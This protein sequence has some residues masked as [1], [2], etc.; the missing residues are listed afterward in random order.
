M[1]ISTVFK[2]KW[3]EHSSCLEPGQR[4]ESICSKRRRHVY[5]GT[6]N[7]RNQFYCPDNGVCL[8]A[9]RIQHSNASPNYPTFEGD[10]WHAVHQNPASFL[11]E[12]C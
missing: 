10:G 6:E 8:S 5:S 4:E 9:D 11:P 12:P 3:T 1:Y 2:L 7:I